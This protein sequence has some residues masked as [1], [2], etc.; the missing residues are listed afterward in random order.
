MVNKGIELIKVSFGGVY[1]ETKTVIMKLNSVLCVSHFI[2][3][4]PV[5]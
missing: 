5:H 1:N 4:T 2:D 3:C